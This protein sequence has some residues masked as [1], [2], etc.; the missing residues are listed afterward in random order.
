M[1]TIKQQTDDNSNDNDRMLQL[2]R[3]WTEIVDND[4][5]IML[6]LYRS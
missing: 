5:D 1:I 6:Q 4:N 2:Y 3:S